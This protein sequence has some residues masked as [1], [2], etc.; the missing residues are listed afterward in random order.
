MAL[1]LSDVI[2][3][4][5]TGTTSLSWAPPLA[6]PTPRQRST[7]ATRAWWRVSWRGRWTS[8]PTPTS[9]RPTTTT[10]T[11]SPD[12]WGPPSSRPLQHSAG[13]P[14]GSGLASRAR[15]A[16]W[17]RPG[18][19]AP[20]RPRPQSAPPPSRTVSPYWTDWSHASGLS[21]SSQPLETKQM[22]SRPNR[23]M[24]RSN[25]AAT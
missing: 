18:R 19:A 7:T 25:R 20:A 24:N 23:E 14:A 3:F 17:C 8:L 6:T 11:T 22:D 2:D 4:Q 12:L 9:V 15:S 21:R 16:W 1:S 13:T 5:A 10:T